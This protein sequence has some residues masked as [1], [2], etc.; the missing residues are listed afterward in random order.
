MSWAGTNLLPVP[1]LGQTG[2]VKKQQSFSPAGGVLE[3]SKLKGARG[4]ELNIYSSNIYLVFSAV[5]KLM[6][7]G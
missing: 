2:S 1:D 7:P 4:S 6:I 5:Q 3:S